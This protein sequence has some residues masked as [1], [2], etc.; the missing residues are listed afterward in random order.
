MFASTFIFFNSSGMVLV[1]QRGLLSRSSRLV[2]TGLNSSDFYFSLT[3]VNG[4]PCFPNRRTIRVRVKRHNFRGGNIRVK[5]S[6]R[7]WR[8][9]R[10]GSFACASWFEQ[11]IVRLGLTSFSA[12]G[13]YLPSKL[14]EEIPMSNH[15]LQYV[16]TRVLDPW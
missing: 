8:Y 1:D 10:V 6:R 4:W 9:G 16:S 11:C 13:I 12:S 14:A 15:F 7:R 2:F 3:I 5:R